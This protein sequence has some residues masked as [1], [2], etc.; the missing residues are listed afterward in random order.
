[1]NFG[2]KR[3]KA[4]LFTLVSWG[5]GDKNANRRSDPFSIVIATLIFTKIHDS[6]CDP[7]FI[8]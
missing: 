1:M 2:E 6:R 8:Y 5:L 7:R 3:E 4:I